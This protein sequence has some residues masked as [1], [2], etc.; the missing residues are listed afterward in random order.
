MRKNK[1]TSAGIVGREGCS[2]AKICASIYKIYR[3][4]SVTTS[5]TIRGIGYIAA[6]GCATPTYW[7][8]G[9]V[10]ASSRSYLVFVLARLS[11]RHGPSFAFAFALLGLEDPFKI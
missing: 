8:L 2:S 1:N 5:T 9:A 6:S 7:R 11:G 10:G 4:I 3:R